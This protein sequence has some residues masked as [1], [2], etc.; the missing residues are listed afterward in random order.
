MRHVPQRIQ[1]IARVKGGRLV[2][3]IREALVTV[4]LGAAIQSPLQ[5]LG[6]PGARQTSQAGN[7]PPPPRNLPR[8]VIDHAG[9]ALV[10]P[11]RRRLGDEAAEV[12]DSPLCTVVTGELA[13]ALGLGQTLGSRHQQLALP[14]LCLRLW[15]STHDKTGLICP[16]MMDG[17]GVQ[18]PAVGT[19]GDA[20]LRCTGNV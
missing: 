17:A 5:V 13:V 14:T 3:R 18:G 4:A 12:G 11:R 6:V 9:V 16:L 19:I 2:A 15:H 20:Q 10:R 8:R 1:G 7:T